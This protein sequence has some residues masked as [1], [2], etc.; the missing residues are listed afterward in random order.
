MVTAKP[1]TGP[2][3]NQKSRTVAMRAVTLESTM[4]E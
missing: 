3:P 4:V 1:R 2:E